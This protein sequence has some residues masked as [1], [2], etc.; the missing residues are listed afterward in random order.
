[1]LF[2]SIYF[3]TLMSEFLINSLICYQ[4]ISLS[5]RI[6]FGL[7]KPDSTHIKYILQMDVFNK[8]S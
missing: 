3:F 5:P 7:V 2:Q 1:M 4:N 6:K 8:E